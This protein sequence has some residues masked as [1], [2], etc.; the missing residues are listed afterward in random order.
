MLTTH[1]TAQ[2]ASWSDVAGTYDL[3]FGQAMPYQKPK[4]LSQRGFWGD[5]TNVGKDV[6]NAAEGNADLSKSVTFDVSVGHQGQKTNIYTDDKGHLTLDC[7]NCFITGS[8]EVT[9]H[10]SVDNFQLQDLKLTSPNIFQAELELEATI[11]SSDSPDSLQYTKELFS[12]TVPD[13]EIE[14]EGIF[15]LGAILSYDVGVSSSFSGSATVDFGIKA[16]IPNNAQLIA[17]I[18]DTDQSS[19]N[20]FDISDVTSFFDIT[21]ESASITLAAF[22]RPKLSFGIEL[23]EVRY[24]DVA[25]TVKLQEVSVTLSAEYDEAGACSQS[26]ESSKT[27]VK[28]DSKVDVEVDLQIDASIGNDEETAKPSWSKQLWG[29]SEPLES[30]CFPLDIPGLN[31]NGNSTSTAGLP[32]STIALSR[33]LTSRVSVLGVATQNSIA[34]PSSLRATSIATPIASTSSSDVFSAP[35]STSSSNT[36]NATPSPGSVAP[37]RSTSLTSSD[38]QYISSPSRSASIDYPASSSGSSP[39]TIIS[40]TSSMPVNDISNKK[41]AVLL[42]SSGH[43]HSSCPESS[44]TSK[45]F[46]KTNSST[47]AAEEPS[48]TSSHMIATPSTKEAPLSTKEAPLSTTEKPSRATSKSPSTTETEATSLAE[49]GGG[50]C[51]MVKRFGKRMLIC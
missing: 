44:V 12:F 34:S 13:A 5:I 31:G 38:A 2:P 20:G 47:R 3:D 32:A 23:I 50:G 41:A 27:G 22:S 18:Q 24:F 9:G 6:L 26:A 21:K 17:D 29:V 25:I 48:T 15:K 43:A 10:F 1:F 14:V 39:S 4:E 51:R 11:T 35:V 16:G 49:S 40:S 42:P 19:A 45:S 37:T 8:F 46:P 28:L 7:I 33:A 30:M 36:V